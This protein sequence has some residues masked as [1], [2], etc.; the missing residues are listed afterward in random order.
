MSDKGRSDDVGG[1]GGGGG[2]EAAVHA[3]VEVTNKRRRYGE[4][5]KKAKQVAVYPFRNVK[6]K[7]YRK[8]RSSSANPP[9][10][11]GCYLCF[12]SPHTSDSPVTRQTS[13]PKSPEFSYDSLKALIENND[14]FSRECNVHMDIS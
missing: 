11:G 6:K 3:E 4:K 7:L 14:F 13:D 12:M 9:G 5:I 10:E 8:K 2:D 1:G